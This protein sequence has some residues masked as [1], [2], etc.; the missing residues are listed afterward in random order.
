[1]ILMRSLCEG[2]ANMEKVYMIVA[3][4]IIRH[5]SG[6]GWILVDSFVCGVF[7]VTDMEYVGDGFAEVGRMHPM[8]M[9]DMLR[10]IKAE[11]GM[12]Y[13]RAEFFDKV[14]LVK[15]E[16][17]SLW[18]ADTDEN[19]II[20]YGNAVQLAHE[21]GKSVYAILDQLEEIR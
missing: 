14:Y 9:Y 13:D 21:W 7:N 1:M 12:E 8:T 5:G 10:C 18:G 20:T 6:D 17:W 4:D 3:G 2:G 19:T 15:P 16:Y 11:S